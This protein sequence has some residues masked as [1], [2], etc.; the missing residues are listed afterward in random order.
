MLLIS[1]SELYK[2]KIT[3]NFKIPKNNL[4]TSQF[5]RDVE[6]GGLAPQ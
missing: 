3:E 5:L 6:Y 1:K 2:V 4:M